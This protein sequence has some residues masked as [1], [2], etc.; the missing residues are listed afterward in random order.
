MGCFCPAS[1]AYALLAPTLRSAR[2]RRCTSCRFANAKAP[3]LDLGLCK[4]ALVPVATIQPSCVDRVS[5]VRRS[6]DGKCP[7]WAITSRT[8]Q[9]DKDKSILV[10]KESW[11]RLEIPWCK[12]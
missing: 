4:H 9:D 10:L 3:P 12:I 11:S 2:H 8:Y 1:L 6:H 5:L 7:A